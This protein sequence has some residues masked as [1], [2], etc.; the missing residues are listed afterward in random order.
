MMVDLAGR[1]AVVV[2][3]G[4][5]AERKVRGL[6]A[7][8]AAVT[9]VSPAA[10][11]PLERFAAAGRLEIVRRA[12]RM[13]DLRGAF[14]V[15][16][17]TDSAEVNRRV[18]AAAMRRGALVNVADD[19]AACTF[20]VP[21]AVR[22]G[23]LT[24]AVSTGGGSPALAK[25]LRQ[26]LEKVIGPEYEALVDALRALRSAARRAVP[27]TR[28]RQALFRQALA[29]PLCDEAARGDRRAVRARIAALVAQARAGRP[30]RS[31]RP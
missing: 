14:L 22:R 15:L 17:A 29:S 28:A 5:V 10:T 30:A 2:G 21:A 19:P 1:R 24:I 18:A 12:V 4:A 11:A 13:S 26:R 9:V 31:R 23:D 7:C 6:L 20:Q 8:R 16:A 27:D 25:Q 3:G